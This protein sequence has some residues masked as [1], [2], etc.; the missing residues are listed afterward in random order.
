MLTVDLAGVAVRRFTVAEPLEAGTARVADPFGDGAA[1]WPTLRWT[2][3]ETPVGFP[4]TELVA[5]WTART[6][7][8]G[9]LEVEL[10]ARTAAGRTTKWYSMGR[11]AE[12]DGDVHRTSVPGQG[13]EDGDVAVDTFVARRPV[14]AYR[15]RVT[16]YGSGVRVE[17]LAVMASAVP[18]RSA[19]PVSPPGPGR[20]VALDVP[21]LSQQA[22]AGHFPQWDGGG[23]NWCGPASLAMVMAYW[24]RGPGPEELAWVPPQ[25]PCP[26]VDHAAG[27]TYDHSYQGTGN[28]SFGVAYA[29][30]YGLDGLVTRLRS[31]RE[32]ERLVAAGIPVITSQSF[33]E[34]ELPGAGYST[35]G[36]I[37]VVAGFTREGDVIANDPAAPGDSGVRRVYPRAA[38]ENVWLRSSGS[39]G[40]AY[41]IHPPGT[42]L[43]PSD[44]TW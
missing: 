8:G 15:V 26:A 12:G 41:V 1:T 30:R 42:P 24:G 9:W 23:Q 37:M 29:G 18:Y 44:G 39:G 14:E 3:E 20:G 27:G 22:H 40:I 6:R 4:A 33:R 16:M 21:R 43:P 35:G 32:L 36:H 11:W 7:P 31:L 38:F 25:D 17:R 13:D 34:H 19:V 10:Q 2:S 5:S 28:W